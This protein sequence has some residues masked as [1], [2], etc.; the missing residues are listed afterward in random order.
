MNDKWMYLKFEIPDDEGSKLLEYAKESFDLKQ[1]DE[2][3]CVLKREKDNSI[4]E[5]SPCD[6]PRDRKLDW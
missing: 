5:I 6:K 2:D 3:W 1:I 4:I